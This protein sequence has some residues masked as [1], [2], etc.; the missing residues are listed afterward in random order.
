MDFFDPFLGGTSGSLIIAYA[1]PNSV[2]FANP[3]Q[4][5]FP[6]RTAQDEMLT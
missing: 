4:N 1:R 5:V 2:D 3:C 6:V